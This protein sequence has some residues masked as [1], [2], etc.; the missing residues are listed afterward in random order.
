MQNG[1]M[2]PPAKAFVDPL[3]V[4]LV[5]TLPAIVFARRATRRDRPARFAVNIALLSQIVLTILSIEAVV[6]LVEDSLTVPRG[7]G[8][9]AV[10]V[11]AA[12]GS[13]P[14]VLSTDTAERVFTA[15][16]WW[17]LHPRAK[18]VM[19][20]ADTWADSST[21]SRTLRHMRRMAIHFG[22]PPKQI[23]LEGRSR[24]TREHPI[25]V[26]RLAGLDASTPVGVVTSA[27]H[28]RRTRDAFRRHFT[29]VIAHP[30][31]VRREPLAPEDFL[32][33]SST[34]ENAMEALQEWAGIAWYALRS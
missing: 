19:S 17:R 20:G 1:G 32:P 18:L 12:G 23:V 7:V 4:V 25:E 15:V 28:M 24:N 8:R 22:V 11:V 30:V 21:G 14:D 16:E 34:L 26:G 3:L 9:P 27:I 6:R 33:S 29:T 2:L 10:I 31:V 5:V 13:E